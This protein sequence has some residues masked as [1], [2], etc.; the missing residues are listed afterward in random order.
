MKAMTIAAVLIAIMVIP[1]VFILCDEQD[2]SAD[3]TTPVIPTQD[4]SVATLT[5]VSSGSDGGTNYTNWQLD[6]TVE[7]THNYGARFD[8]NDQMS[9][10][11]GDNGVSTSYFEEVSP[12]GSGQYNTNITGAGIT[13]TYDAIFLSP[14]TGI[15]VGG[16]ANT[17][18]DIT[19][20]N[21]YTSGYQSSRWYV[22][23]TN[24][25][26]TMEMFN[27]ITIVLHVTPVQYTLTF[28]TDGGSFDSTPQTVYNEG[29][30]V[31]LPTNITRTN[32]SFVAWELNGV[33]VSQV[34]M[35]QDQ[36]VVA[37][38]LG[39]PYTVSFNPGLGTVDT[40][41]KSVNYGGQYGAL[42]TPTWTGRTFDGWYTASSGGT[43]I[44]SGSTYNTVGDQTLYAHWVS[45]A[46]YWSNGNMNGSLSILYHI[47][48][49]NA[50]NEIENTIRLY[51]Y[52]PS[53]ADD[54]STIFNES[55]I[56]TGYYLMIEVVSNRV[57]TTYVAQIFA[58]L[59][60]SNNTEIMTES[61]D[62][63]SW[64]GFIVSVDSLNGTVSYTKVM[65]FRSFTDYQESVGDMIMNYSSGGT[66]SGLSM[67]ELEMNSISSD[68]PR[69][70]VIKTNVF[71]NTYGVV[72]TDPAI[73]ISDYFP[74]IPYIRLN[75]Y[76]FALYG[77][78]MTVNGHTM[79]V[80]SPNITLYYTVGNNG[81]I[82]ADAPGDGISSKQLVLKN[83]Y[84]TWNEEGCFLTFADENF[85]VN[86]GS[87]T[88]K[89]VSFDGI[90]YFA[91]AIYEPY[92]ARESSYEVDWWNNNFD[93]K[94][95]GI[96]MAGLLII[97]GLLAKA[98]IGGR[99][100]DYIII[101]IAVVIALIMAGGIVNA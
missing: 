78:S 84:V 100:I 17:S 41:S 83:I 57:G 55:F 18:G 9:N 92:T 35:D 62:L 19:Y 66:Y 79:N 70:S 58:T 1:S 93:V 11:A 13:I 33:A 73:D 82:I 59:Y 22:K 76:S 38:W 6:I 8:C 94:A 56:D 81:P 99:A 10:L 67:Y 46:T 87:Y 4:S 31:T 60:D 68:V 95:F 71:L 51:R 69:Q 5:F 86:M 45:N 21:Q 52:D 47:D 34:T 85:T 28:N 50:T 42:P 77:N 32:Y 61:V 27:F 90:W 74:D 72:M 91:M 14:Y 44:T 98:T 29:T 15:I 97:L 3:T 96:V 64:N 2:S 63:G 65:Q 30:V 37:T 16:T 43:L 40:P 89:A 12:S 88:N 101:G 25:A 24:S 23:T 53:V 36:T 54:L 75:F 80:T 39:D 49:T 48:N 20:S 7:R 26:E